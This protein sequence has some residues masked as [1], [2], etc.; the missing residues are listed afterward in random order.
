MYSQPSP[1]RTALASTTALPRLVG[2]SDA[3]SAG[4][5]VQGEDNN[6]PCQEA[7]GGLLFDEECDSGERADG[8]ERSEMFQGD[9][10]LDDISWL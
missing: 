4:G 9:V 8:D 2:R 10:D 3:C 7:A 6:K 5:W 1:D